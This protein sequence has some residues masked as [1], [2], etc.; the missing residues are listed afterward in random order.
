MTEATTDHKNA[1]IAA[2]IENWNVK[3]ADLTVTIDG[4]TYQA[5]PSSIEQMTI[6]LQQ[7]NLPDGFFWVDSSNVKVSFDKAA[8]QSLADTS[9]AARFTLFSTFQTRRSAI[10]AAT[11]LEEIADLI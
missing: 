1:Q 5:N 3:Y 6:N 4:K 2:N 10:L 11:T 7:T 8:L 9:I